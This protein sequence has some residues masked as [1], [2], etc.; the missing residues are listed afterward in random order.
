MEYSPQSPEELR[1]RRITSVVTAC[2]FAISAA[3]VGAAYLQGT[4]ALSQN[5]LA[6]A[7]KHSAEPVVESEATKIGD[8]ASLLRACATRDLETF[9]EIEMGA[10]DPLITPGEL[11]DATFKLLDARTACR[12]GRFEEAFNTYDEVLGR[13]SRAAPVANRSRASVT[14]RPRGLP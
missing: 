2:Y 14:A 1:A 7:H 5:Q 4:P 8:V 9:I 6:S 13:L 11:S 12:T 10:D 3:I